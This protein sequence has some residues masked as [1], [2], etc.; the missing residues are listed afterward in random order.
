MLAKLMSAPKVVGVK[1]TRKAI[2]EGRAALV[3][4]ARDADPALT[5][6]LV[7]ACTANGIALDTSDTMAELGKACGIAVGASV[8]AVLVSA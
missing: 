4:L 2:R 6:P 5:E 3:F 7:G 8:A 1:Q